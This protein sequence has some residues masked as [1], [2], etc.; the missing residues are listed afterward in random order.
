MCAQTCIDTRISIEIC[1]ASYATMCSKPTG[2]LRISAGGDPLELWPENERPKMV[3]IFLAVFYAASF[4][5]STG[6]RSFFHCD[7]S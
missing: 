5:L 3:E 6:G 2:G 7:R 4:L 1:G